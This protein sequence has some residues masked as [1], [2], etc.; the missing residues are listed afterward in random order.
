MGLDVSGSK[1]EKTYHAGYGGLHLIR[2]LAMVSLGLP[3]KIKDQSTFSAVSG[4]ITLQKDWYQDECSTVL[5]YVQASGYFF[6]NLMFHCDCDGSYTKNGKIFKGSG[7]LSGNSTELLKEL[8]YL[9]KNM[10]KKSDETARAIDLFKMFYDVVKDEVVNG[11]G[12][13][14]FH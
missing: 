9:K 11:D 13:I 3:T 8:E 4:S 12:V 1:T 2:W 7:L 6:P 14:E 5:Y 10:P